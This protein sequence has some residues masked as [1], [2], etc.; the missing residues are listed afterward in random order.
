M[1]ATRIRL[2]TLC[3]MFFIAL[4]LPARAGMLFA[5]GVDVVDDAGAVPTAP[6][7]AAYDALPLWFD[8]MDEY[9][10][11]AMEPYRD[12]YDDLPI[13]EK[14]R[15]YSAQ[16]EY[17]NNRK[18]NFHPAALRGE[19]EEEDGEEDDG[20]A[21]R[22]GGADTGE[23]W[24]EDEEE[25]LAAAEEEE[26]D[27]ELLQEDDGDYDILPMFFADMDR[28]DQIAMEPYRDTYDAMPVGEKAEAYGR[29]F[30][31]MRDREPNF[32][33]AVINAVRR[34]AA[35]KASA[36][37]AKRFLYKPAT[38]KP[39]R[40]TEE[41][42]TGEVLKGLPGPWEAN[43][44]AAEEETKERRR[45]GYRSD[46]RRMETLREGWNAVDVLRGARDR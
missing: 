46:S 41:E 36:Y 38:P 25:G 12:T 40:P 31:F 35:R 28:Y 45:S 15:L 4:C 30:A 11:I 42:Q 32:N 6:A 33:P 43:Q 23:E 13:E 29:Q 22:G 5:G 34:S 37:E 27:L 1:S 7:A 26:A 9:D 39:P 17:L 24:D 18:P 44:A 3:A 10:Q 8:D 14:A 21:S 19:E 2:I 20:F 16:F